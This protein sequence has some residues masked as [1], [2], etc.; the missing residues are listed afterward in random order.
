MGIKSV[1]QTT[2]SSA[3]GGSNVITVTKTDGTTSTFTVKN[4]SKGSTGAAGADGYT[5]VKGTDY[6]TADDQQSIVDAVLAA[7]PTAEGV[8]F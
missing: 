7:L 5:P 3:D 2:T 4:G 1:T 8:S 6:W